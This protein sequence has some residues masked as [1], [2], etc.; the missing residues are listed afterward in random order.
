MEDAERR[1]SA[2][3][4]LLAQEGFGA[5]TDEPIVRRPNGARAPLSFAQET[6]W[7]L[8]RASPGMTAYNSAVARRVHGELDI[9]ALRNALDALA[10]RHEAL[11]TVVDASGE[12]PA[13]DVRPAGPVP[14]A[15]ADVRTLPQAD[16]EAAARTLLRDIA[17]TPFDLTRDLPLRA[18]L[19]RVADDEYFFLL[20]THHIA[21]DAWSYDLM[22]RDL[23]ALY[24]AAR[25]N[26]IAA[27]PAPALQFADYAAWQRATLHGER[28]ERALSFW[29]ERLA[30]LPELELPT[31]RPR[32]AVPASDGARCAATLAPAL[33]ADMRRL[34][35]GHGATL[36]A[37]LLAVYAT[38]LHRISGGDE[39]VV[40]SA[41]AARTRRDVEDIVGY[42]SAVLPMRINFAGDPTFAELLRRTM[43]VTVSAFEHQD[44]P[45]EEAVVGLQRRG[46]AAHA[47][48]FR[49][50]LTMQD[51]LA[52]N[53]RLG[54]A[55]TEA[56][57]IEGGQTKFDMT[58]LATEQRGGLELSLWY[59]TDLF[60]ATT[61]ARFLGRLGHVVES[62]VRDPQQRI[63]E[64]DLLLPVEREE[65]AA[66][67]ATARTFG[68]YPTVPDGMAAAAARV[69]AATAVVCGEHRLTYG[70]L[71][72]AAQRL[73]RRLRSTAVAPG[74]AVGLYVDRSVEG[75]VA[76]LAAWE[77]R[78]AYVPLAIDAP[79]HR[80]LSQLSE[81]RITT[82]ITTAALR[83]RLPDTVHS[84][85]LDDEAHCG[86]RDAAENDAAATADD[87]ARRPCRPDD[88]AY[89][90]FTSGSTGVPKGVAVTHG[91]LANYTQAIAATLGVTPDAPLGF[92]SVS[93]LSA[94]LGNTAIFPALCSG[95]TL[96]LIAADVATDAARFAAYAQANPYDVL[97]ITP[98][99]LG[100]LLDGTARAELLPRQTLVLGGEACSWELVE[101]VR[102]R[103]RCRIINHY[104][105]TEATVGACTFT[106]DDSP[107]GGI[108][109]STVPIGK[110]L[111][112]V[113]CYVLDGRRKPMPVGVAGELYVGGAGLAR[114]YVHR[115]ELTAE[116]FGAD[117]F[118]K[119][120]EARMYRTGDRVR[121]LPT[122][123]LEF[124]GRL[125][126]QVKIRGY[127]VE[128]GEIENV[129]RQ[130][131]AVAACA[132]SLSGGGH[133]DEVRLR[134]YVVLRYK[135]SA[136]DA[137]EQL[138]TSLAERLPEYMR[139]Q[140]IVPLQQLP[141]TASG[142]LDRAALGAYAAQTEEDRFVAPRTPTEA[143]IAEVWAEVLKRERVGVTDDFL[144]L[145]GHS[146]LAI[147]VLGKLARRFGVRLSLRTL[148]DARTVAAL[149]RE[150]ETGVPSEARAQPVP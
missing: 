17:D 10:A 66:W 26:G 2:F 93:P 69:P 4:Q 54:N 144:A 37:V 64:L 12:H 132:V 130:N 77:A 145:G 38:V 147:R 140:T 119:G 135:T 100:A 89:V 81:G 137:I 27:L 108:I 91:N 43:D 122:G 127:R 30:D 23:A 102:R 149:A 92:A 114:G 49:V 128:L 125:D 107:V 3:E 57:E 76:M 33:L 61:V 133:D 46:T 136:N 39:V 59:R 111:A 40:G 129:L 101:R 71:T 72:S 115:P 15:L 96:H 126:D 36:Y 44:V 35:R 14:L 45:F 60:E 124:L 146:I 47:P 113:R 65:L 6:L 13:L 19:V 21:S 53:L 120:P 86:A 52:Q 118:A 95:G 8:D 84:I 73:G 131:A 42:F 94:D 20:L 7:L 99:H 50:V 104:G 103:S 106:V 90:L 11:R 1:R 88:V 97:K 5:P 68:A 79:V 75:V 82:V 110:P 16:R 25:G 112:N 74:D 29:R 78:A 63:A 143:G 80:T 138:Q 41:V 56:L 139:P 121:R 31:D 109:P 22:F 134:A 67:N 142:K 98:T 34:A 28:L 24:D 116:R 105:P 123:D 55:T 150:I 83:R 18:S 70:E 51:A 148:F 48:L 87:A 85:V 117:P 141:F 9:A 62:V 32:S 58:L